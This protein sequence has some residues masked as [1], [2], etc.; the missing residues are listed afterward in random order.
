[1]KG[2]GLLFL[3]QFKKNN[4]KRGAGRDGR[5]PAFPASLGRTDEFLPSLPPL[6]GRTGWIGR[7]D[8]RDELT[9]GR[10]QADPQGPVARAEAGRHDG[11]GHDGLRS[12]CRKMLWLS[13]RGHY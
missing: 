1:M 6:D 3:I 13:L 10:W 12:D 9:N 2:C 4:R 7:T 8:G 11:V 5:I